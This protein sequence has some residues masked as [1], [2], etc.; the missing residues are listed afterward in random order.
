M[1]MT[2]REVMKAAVHF[3]GPDRLPV[4]FDALGVTDGSWS[5]SGGATG[6]WTWC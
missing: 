3:K 4:I 6:R 1:A 5:G 2:S